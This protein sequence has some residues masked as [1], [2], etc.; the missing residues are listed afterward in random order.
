[1]ASVHQKIENDKIPPYTTKNRTLDLFLVSKVNQIILGKNF[2]LCAPTK[3]FPRF[4]LARFGFDFF[5]FCD[6]FPLRR[7][8]I[9]KLETEKG[10]E[11][12]R[13]KIFLKSKV[14]S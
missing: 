8:Q 3:F 7:Q 6:I 14:S 12:L 1:M 13:R 2:S 10:G 4:M 9:N 11:K 5:A